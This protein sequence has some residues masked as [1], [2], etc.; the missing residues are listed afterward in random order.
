MEVSGTL[1][2][3]SPR[4]GGNL[5]LLLFD[6]HITAMILR[7]YQ[8]WLLFFFFGECEIQY[9]LITRFKLFFAPS[10][11]GFQFLIKKIRCCVQLKLKNKCWKILFF[12]VV[13]FV[14]TDKMSKAKDMGRATTKFISNII[15]SSTSLTMQ[16][17]MQYLS[18]SE[19]LHLRSIKK[20]L[21]NNLCGKTVYRVS[22]IYHEV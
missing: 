20:K 9:Y 21:S 10:K 8:S 15:P 1:W 16:V 3:Q 4:Q 18:H 13:Q 5:Y 7:G 6:F 19:L 14:L 11:T 22:V 2:L 12:F 17:E